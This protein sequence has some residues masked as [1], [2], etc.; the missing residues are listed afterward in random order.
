MA[1][2]SRSSFF[3]P[4]TETQT[5]V[6]ATPD[7]DTDDEDVE[8]Q[9]DEANPTQ[10]RS[11]TASKEASKK[12]LTDNPIMDEL[13]QIMIAR[14]EHLVDSGFLNPQFLGKIKNDP[15]EML[16]FIRKNREVVGD[17]LN[18]RLN[19]NIRPTPQ[20]LVQQGIVPKGYFTHGHEKAMTRKH[21]RKSTA[22]QDLA[23]FIQLRPK[24]EQ[25]EAKG[26]LSK[27]EERKEEEELLGNDPMGD[28]RDR[29]TWEISILGTLLFKTI[30]EALSSSCIETQRQEEQV[31]L[32]MEE[33]NRE[34]KNLRDALDKYFLDEE[35]DVLLFAAEEE[36]IR[37]KFHGI[38]K[39][40]LNISTK[41]NAIHE[42]LKI[43]HSVESAMIDLQNIYD[44]ELGQ[45]RKTECD[46]L[47]DLKEQRTRREKA[48]KIR[49][50][51]KSRCNWACAKLDYA[52][53]IAARHQNDGAFIES[54][55]GFLTSLQQISENQNNIVRD[56]DFAID[57][58]ESHLLSIRHDMSK[59]RTMTFK[60]IYD[61][62]KQVEIAES[63]E[64]GNRRLSVASATE[65][66]RE[67]RHFGT[68]ITRQLSTLSAQIEIFN[69]NKYQNNLREIIDI[70]LVMSHNKLKAFFSVFTSSFTQT[71]CDINICYQNLNCLMDE[72]EE[73]ESDHYDT[74]NKS[75]IKKLCMEL[76][77]IYN[78][79]LP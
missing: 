79:L 64:L 56:F 76:Y 62:H 29:E 17:Q 67:R 59:V 52:K 7:P 33:M 71:I 12:A 22:Q 14:F 61:L 19:P 13:I 74:E 75:K 69:I 35:P 2:W 44:K 9:I 72:K 8:F 77:G 73:A 6:N 48:I 16:N 20:Q 37:E 57:E 55:N 78:V 11:R 58:L 32:Q 42:K 39:K 4:D 45:L 28:K 36:M 3:N 65:I 40:L 63:L 54:L 18:R 1:D 41:Q 70:Q 27:N 53:S 21:R 50:A 5:N 68:K 31:L 26:I 66:E 43:L 49:I 34:M 47:R 30:S 23:A 51:E 15:Q 10:P 25:M 60:K 24:P 46:V 38:Q